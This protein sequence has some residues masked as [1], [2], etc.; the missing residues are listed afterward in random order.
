[1]DKRFNPDC[2]TFIEVVNYYRKRALQLKRF[3]IEISSINE[4]PYGGYAIF[5][6]SKRKDG[7]YYSLYV[8]HS[9]RGKGKFREFMKEFNQPT[10]LTSD[11]CDLENFLN[12][13]GYPHYV[14]DIYTG[15][16]KIISDYYQ[17]QIAKRSGVYLMNH[18]DEG[19]VI[20]NVLKVNNKHRVVNA[21]AIHP[22]FQSDESLID[23]SNIEYMDDVTL[24][25]IM[26]V[27]EY[28]SVANEYLSKRPIKS[29]EEIRLSPLEVVNDMLKIDKIQN[30]K[31]FD[32]YHK[33]TH[34]RTNELTEYFDNWLKRLDISDEIY[35]Q[36]IDAIEVTPIINRI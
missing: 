23:K 16:Y 35:Q 8:Y 10:I 6:D 4:L 5:N 11:D 32:L 1:M 3:G 9:F 36:C 30:K 33:G 20:A 15:T 31:D 29:I 18:I 19:N 13:N 14:V 17:D 34:P 2:D 26:N 21:Y 12:H 22:I 27:M 24:T 28:R 25:D 7:I